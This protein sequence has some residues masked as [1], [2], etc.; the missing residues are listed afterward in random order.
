[1]G[2]SSRPEPEGQ[3]SR[4]IIAAASHRA[5]ADVV[6]GLERGQWG[7]PVDRVTTTGI[8]HSMGGMMVLTQADE[9]GGFDRVAL[10][11]WSNQTIGLTETQGTTLR[12]MAIPEGYHPSPR[13]QMR[14]LFYAEDVPL[15]LIEADEAASCLTPSCMGR[16]ALT[17]G[18]VAEASA[19][20]TCPVFLLYGG[21]DISPDPRQEVA[22]FKS[23]PHITLALEPGAAHCHNLASQR[24]AIW[25][26]LAAWIG[27]LR[28]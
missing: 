26:S 8:G 22:F 27:S 24:H 6:A 11:G 20:L 5:V 12:E 16:D 19:R 17:P 7:N 10:L 18:I 25:R 28:S 23:S 1:M 3:L 4:A 14:P 9:C 2:E 15:E 21:V 13:Q